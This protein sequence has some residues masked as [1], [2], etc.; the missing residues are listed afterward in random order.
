M[1]KKVLFSGAVSLVVALT[2]LGIIAV[3][4]SAEDANAR[5]SFNSFDYKG[6]KIFRLK[7]N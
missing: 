5:K 3:L 6:N 2:L 4:L 7:F 1:A